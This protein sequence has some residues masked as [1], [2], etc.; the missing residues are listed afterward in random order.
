[1]TGRR[2]YNLFPLLVGPVEGWSKRLPA[3]AA[4]GFDTLYLNPF[5]QT[6]FS[7]SLYAVQDYFRLDRRFKSPA[8][9]DDMARLSG[10]IDAARTHGLAAMMDLVVNHTA[11][12]AVLTHEHPDWYIRDHDGEVLSP[13][14][15]DPIDPSKRTIWG[16]LAELDWHDGPREAMAAYFARVVRHYADLG[17]RGFRCDAAYKVPTAVWRGLTDVARTVDPE[18][19]FCAETLGCTPA[20]VRAL[21][22]AG[23]DYLFNS[24]KW[25]DGKAPWFLEQYDLYRRIAPAIGFPESHDTQR[26]AAELASEGIV[27]PA[28]LEA[29]YRRR[30]LIAA[31][32]SAG[33][34][35]PIGY[36]TGARRPLHVVETTP[37]DQEAPLFDL[38]EF[39]RATHRM[40][41]TI[42]AFNEDGPMTVLSGADDE[43]VVLARWT[44]ALDD[45]AFVLINTDRLHERDVDVAALLAITGD[46][47]VRLD[48][49]TPGTA[50]PVTQRRLALRP[51][52]VRVLHAGFASRVQEV[53]DVPPTRGDLPPRIVI[54]EV[55][56]EIDGGRF[57]VKRIQGDEL[58]VWADI[59]RDGH[60]KIA[61]AIRLQH[62]GEAHWTL[63]PMRLFDNDRWVGRVRLERI[64]R[65]HFTIEAWTDHFA[66]WCD[67]VGKKRDAAQAVHLELTEGRA[68]LAAAVDRAEDEPRRRL[69]ALL[70]EYDRLS[71]DEARV[72]LLLSRLVG[73]AMALVPD[74]SDRV[75][76]EPVLDVMVDRPAARFSAWY[77]M[78][79]RSQG[80][81][82]GRGARF[83]ECSQRLPAI[84]ELG[85][86]VIY[87]VPIHP[88]GRLNRKGRN[89]STTAAPGEPGSPYAI[90]SAD[91]GHTAIEKE[92]G[93]LEEFRAFQRDVRAHGMEL[94]LDFA[95]QCAP[96]HPWLRQHPQW[97]RRRADGSIKYAENPPKK[98]EDIVN[99]DF[100]QP[101]WRALWQALRDVVLFW[102]DEGVKIFRVDNPHTKPVA[103]WHWLIGEV[104]NRHPDVMFLS[105]AFTRPKMMRRLAKAGFTQSYTY[106]TWRNTKA[107]LTEYLTELTQGAGREYFRPNFFPNTPDILPVFLQTGGRAG[108]RIRFVLAATLSGSY[109]IYNGFELCEAE[110][111]PGREEYANSEKYEY[112]VWDWDR[113]GHIKDDIRKLN[114]L[115]RHSPALQLFTNLRFCEASND[116]VLFYAK[117]TPDRTDMVFVAVTLDP[118]T[119]VETEIV[120]PLEAMGLTPDASFETEELFTGARQV[121]RGARH[122]IAF[123]PTMNPTVVL[124][125]V[126]PA[127]D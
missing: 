9:N 34:M 33:I 2:I 40:K 115:R 100:D 73:H 35:M 92:L 85:F 1:M 46:D 71:D 36:E 14:A 122:N 52:E 65:A 6:G 106:F 91:G 86:D 98:Y 74:K 90:G 82:P 22:G 83:A 118:K 105:E 17:F 70:A 66:S 124:R 55:W 117:F 62:H 113:P 38:A 56:P 125:V 119:P 44:E 110:A 59:Y 26:L 27:E 104:Q 31:T 30:Y 69:S 96:D 50:E 80:T 101:D 123:D 28:A 99:V 15:V 114:E 32:L 121:W 13:F 68:M 45:L 61:A 81:A 89:N 48:D 79:P 37:A 127:A 10:F 102:V 72:E 11:K 107:E 111:L 42:P 51:G 5:H 7:G 47:P 20:Q 97:F 39:L 12:D 112:K 41:A 49:V 23:F 16:D 84:R 18:C 77:E 21:T 64:G 75:V 19:F 120:F 116:K 3:I 95:V 67:E 76:Y 87:L 63:V 108:F 8:S 58:E 109:G 60:D 94:A 25:W 126:C 53:G 88:V 57:P 78:F 54:E 4:L 103:F 24:V 93:T 29:E 43:M